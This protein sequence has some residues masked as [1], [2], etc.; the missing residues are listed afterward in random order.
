MIPNGLI[1]NI[2]GIVEGRRPYDSDMLEEFKSKLLQQLDGIFE[3]LA[4]EDVYY[5]YGD[6]AYPLRPTLMAPFI[7]ARPTLQ[8]QDTLITE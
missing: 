6:P 4:A 7:A 8:Q 5:L 2:F 1:R 3:G